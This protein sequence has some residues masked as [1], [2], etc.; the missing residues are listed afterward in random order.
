MEKL[1]KDKRRTYRNML[2]R[3]LELEYSEEFG[4]VLEKEE[5]EKIE[6]LIDICIENQDTIDHV[7]IGYVWD[8]ADN[9]ICYAINKKYENFLKD[10][11]RLEEICLKYN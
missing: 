8:L 10:S 5:S 11:K 7:G 9:S 3:M 4:K 2:L 6:Q 1:G